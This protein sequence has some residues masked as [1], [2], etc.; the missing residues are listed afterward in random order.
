MLAISVAA[1]LVPLASAD[2]VSTLVL[3]PAN[4][5]GGGPASCSTFT[6]T[7]TVD[8]TSANTFGVSFNI[9]NANP[10]TTVTF[11]FAASSALVTQIQGGAPADVFASADGA[12]MQKL[13]TGGQVTAEPTAFAANLLTIVVKPGNPNKVKSIADLAN[14]DVDSLCGETVPCGKYADQILSGVGVAIDPSHI[15]RGADVKA[16]LAA[17]TTGDAT[18]YH[19]EN[20]GQAARQSLWFHG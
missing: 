8:Q 5:C 15:T 6:F 16:T 18:P 3:S 4:N 7:T 20:V 14:L 12:N 19:R 10:G 1:L 13:V 9:Q 11:N 2:T 17:V